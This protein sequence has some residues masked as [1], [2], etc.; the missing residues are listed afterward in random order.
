MQVEIAV[1]P[2]IGRD[3]VKESPRIAQNFSGA[4]VLARLAGAAG[5]SGTSSAACSGKAG[6]DDHPTVQYFYMLTAERCLA[7]AQVKTSGG[8]YYTAQ[9]QNVLN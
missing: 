5:T 9:R 3:T 4:G 2:G 7:T 6:G 1:K 8:K